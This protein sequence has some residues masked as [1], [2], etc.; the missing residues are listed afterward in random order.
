MPSVASPLIG[1]VGGDDVPPNSSPDQSEIEKTLFGVDLLFTDD[2]QV[3]AS[4]D[5]ATVDGMAAL[6]QAIRIRL[7]T[8]P[9]EYAINPAFGC[10]LMR[11][12]K[13]RASKADR[14]AMRQLII[15]QLTQEE[16]IS[17][18]EDVVVESIT[19]GN[20]TGVKITVRVTALGK[21]NSFAYTHFSD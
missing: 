19:S 15:E 5:Y 8:T 2:L 4:G 10:G 9:G 16:R 7:I 1:A 21:E 13:K 12:V 14:D 6:R 3:T 11:F 18:V 17:K 20:I